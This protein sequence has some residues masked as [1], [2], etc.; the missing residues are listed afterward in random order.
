MAPTTSSWPA[1]PTR[2]PRTRRP[3]SQT[4]LDDLA[5]GKPM[6]RLVCGDV[7]FGK[8]EVALRAAFI[9]A[10]A[11]LQVAVVVPTTLLAR[12]H[13]ATFS[14]TLQGACRCGSR[15]PRAW[16]A[17][18]SWP[19]SRRASRT[20]RIDIVVGTHAL[21]GKSIAFAAPR[22]A[23]RRRGA[24]LR[25]RPQGAPE[26][27]ARGCARADPDRHADPAHAATGAVGRAR[28]V[29]DHH[30]AGRPAGRAHLH[31][32]VRSGHHPRGAAARALSRRAELL[33]RA[34]HLRPRGR[35]RVPGRADAGAEGRA[36]ARPAGAD[37]ARGR[38]DRVL[39]R[40][41][42]R[43]AVDGDRRVRASTS[44]TPTR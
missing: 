7:G 15:R 3:A 16:S 41:V 40:Q 13:F 8:T 29:A 23:G 35:G 20:A 9:A 31:L 17:P 36:R 4:V 26:A 34:A 21:L 6:D 10:M 28:A 11:G 39:R 42:R 1:S 44:R 27:A 25:R 43:A 5:S 24:A 19:P 14:Q 32:A 30:A 22:P 2:R 38:D 33:R 37:R 12:Q 18:R